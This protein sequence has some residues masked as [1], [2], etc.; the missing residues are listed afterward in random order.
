MVINKDALSPGNTL[1]QAC[2]DLTVI[3]L[4][5]RTDRLDDFARQ[6][7][8]IG[9]S[10]DHPRVHLF[11]AVRPSDPGPF[12]TIGARG[13]FL[14]HLEILRKALAEEVD[15]I[16]LC[17]DDLNFSRDL[18]QRI[19]YLAAELEKQDWDILYGFTGENANG[20]TVDPQGQLVSLT[21][22]Q[23][24][25]CAHIL[26]FRRRAIE[27]L[28]PYLEDLLTRPAGDL[29]GGPM[30]VDGAYSWFRKDNPDLLILSIRP[31]IG[32]QRSSATD[33][34]PRKLKDRLP[35]LRQIILVLRKVRNKVVTR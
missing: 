7:H 29:A 35:G 5:E 32:Y 18:P 33:I 12:P 3:N 28:V 22:E 19:A 31:D 16:L 21:A 1:I 17:E 9:L 25:Y 20:P 8:R 34:A 27:R 10:L 24:F 2:G 13:C 26:A 14:S 6:L 23:T 4:P 11:R 30:H 15:S